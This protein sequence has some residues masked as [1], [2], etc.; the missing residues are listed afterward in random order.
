MTHSVKDVFTQGGDLSGRIGFRCTCGFKTGLLTHGK[1]TEMWHS[2]IQQYTT[3]SPL[4]PALPQP[5]SGQQT[6]YE[7][8]L[9][10]AE[11]DALKTLL[12][13]IIAE[14]F[15]AAPP[16]KEHHPLIGLASTIAGIKRTATIEGYWC[17]NCS[18]TLVERHGGICRRCEVLP[19][20]P[21][22]NPQESRPWRSHSLSRIVSDG[23]T[24][25]MFCRCGRTSTSRV[26]SQAEA[27]F[28]EHMQ[29][30]G[31]PPDPSLRWGEHTINR[32]INHESENS[33][34][35]DGGPHGPVTVGPDAT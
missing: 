34:A 10:N 30:V 25:W 28:D 23:E 31:N 16:I 6:R 22:P 8:T 14:R 3:E 15:W 2:H 27:A 13:G 20:A 1:A 32:G 11:L 24:F 4:P 9:T 29:Q 7:L 33:V 21:H 19:K 18:L 12:E 26:W 35:P 17:Q 5:I